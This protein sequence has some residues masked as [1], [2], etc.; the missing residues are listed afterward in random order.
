MESEKH[1]LVGDQIYNGSKKTAPKDLNLELKKMLEDFPR[2]ALHSYRIKFLH[3]RS[4]KEM[5]FEIPLPDDLKTLHN[6][7]EQA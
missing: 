5:D 1:S 2:Q 6:K 4:G 7:L 3:P